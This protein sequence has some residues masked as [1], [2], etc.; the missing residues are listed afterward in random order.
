MRTANFRTLELENACTR[1]T[2]HLVTC[3]GHNAEPPSQLTKLLIYIIYMTDDVVVAVYA[4]D[5]VTGYAPSLA[6]LEARFASSKVRSSHPYSA[7]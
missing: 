7:N 4:S 2:C 3:L 6:S 1:V 5:K